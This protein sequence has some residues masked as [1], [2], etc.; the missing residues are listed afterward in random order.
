[1][2][3]AATRYRAVNGS[4]DRLDL[5]GLVGAVFRLSLVYFLLLKER[6]VITSIGVLHSHC[7]AVSIP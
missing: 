3:R 5:A 1:M 2:L 4:E 6:L 7:L